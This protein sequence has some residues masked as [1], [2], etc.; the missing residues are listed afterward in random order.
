MGKH[1]V[2][3]MQLEQQ[4]NCIDQFTFLE[5]PESLDKKGYER[6]REW[7]DFMAMDT[8][9]P[10]YLVP[11][12]ASRF[13]CSS[14][15]PLTE[16]SRLLHPSMTATLYSEDVQWILPWLLQWLWT[17]T[18]AMALS[19]SEKIRVSQGEAMSPSK[20][21]LWCTTELSSLNILPSLRKEKWFG[22]GFHGMR[23]LRATA[24]QV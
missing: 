18:H 15:S 14:H 8:L 19:P 10:H 17:R 5:R 4:L 12:S 3:W 24:I 9:L 16:S 13:R 11:A 21:S 1:N 2:F 6:Q 23:H 20:L 22:D 7:I